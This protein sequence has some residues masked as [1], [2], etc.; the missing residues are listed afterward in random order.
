MTTYILHGGKT[1]VL[2]SQNYNF[3]GEFTKQVDKDTV[4]V[5]LCYFSRERHKWDD[6][7][8]RDSDSIKKDS[9]KTVQI[10]VAE[11][12]SD[13][14]Q[15]LEKSDVLYIAGGEAELIEPLYSDLASLK[16]KIKGKVYAGSS[17]GFFMAAEQYVLS[18]DA[19]D[20]NT[21]H[22]GLGLLQLQ[23]LCHW[24]QEPEKARKINLL[25]ESSKTPILVLNEFEYSILYN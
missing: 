8:K 25:I 7:I 5:L 1:S 18:A 16:E 13:L 12:P 21:I 22:Q 23:A 2:N 11:N 19:V 14:L 6:L 3:F 15:K 24:D 17:M 10:L 9:N 20:T 4:T